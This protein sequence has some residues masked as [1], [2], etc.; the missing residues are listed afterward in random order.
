MKILLDS[1][2]P[3]WWLDDSAELGA[4]A[5]KVIAEPENLVFFSADSLWE[6]RI[7]GGLGKVDLPP[8]FREVLALEQFETLSVNV[9]RTDELKDHPLASPEPL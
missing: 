8:H 2:F 3:L 1:H 6:L 5:R 4:V 7:K 9:Q